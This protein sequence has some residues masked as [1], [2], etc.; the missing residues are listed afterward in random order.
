MSLLSV[1]LALLSD[2]PTLS[3][4]HCCEPNRLPSGAILVIFGGDLFVDIEC[5][6]R[7]D[8]KQIIN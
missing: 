3:S 6:Q 8:R 1:F 2:T 5:E 7:D 4:G